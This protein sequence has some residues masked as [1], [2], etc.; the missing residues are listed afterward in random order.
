MT[1]HNSYHRPIDQRAPR[2]PVGTSGRVE[3]RLCAVRPY[4]VWGVAVLLVAAG[5]RWLLACTAYLLPNSD[6]VMVGLM[7]RHILAG[8]W[9]AFY[10]GQPYNGTLESWITAGIFRLFGP[11]YAALHVAPIFFSLLFVA[12]AMILGYQLYGKHV[13]LLSGIYLAL[14][15]ALLQ[16]FSVWPGYNYLEA[17]A[18]GTF[19]LTLVLPMSQ[20]RGWARLP[21][22]AFMLG[23]ALWAQ[24]VAIVYA[25]PIAVLLIGP[26][27]AT[28]RAGVARRRL[29]GAAGASLVALALALVPAIIYNLHAHPTTLGFLIG[30]PDNLHVPWYEEARR[31]LLWAAPVFT[32]LIPPTEDLNQFQQFLAEYPLLYGLALALLAQGLWRLVRQRRTLLR[33]CRSLATAHPAGEGA[34]ITLAIALIGVYLFS[35]WGSSSWSAT[36]PRYLLPLFTLTPLLIRALFPPNPSRRRRLY[37]AAVAAIMLAGGL[38]ANAS[39]PRVA[40][41]QRLATYLQARGDDAVYGDYWLVY[42]LAFVSNERLIPVVLRPPLRLGLNRYLPYLQAGLRARRVAWGVQ[43]NSVTEHALLRCLERHHITFQLRTFHMGP[44]R[45]VIVDRLSTAARCL[46]R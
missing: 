40:D 31:L 27:V 44:D 2:W 42:R 14:G 29:L 36:E 38:A 20:D 33:W 17:M 24:P 10:W 9:L 15:P 35:T 45:W 37:G 16:R 1:L 32:G 30:R 25:P 41:V 12:A 11:S 6:Q 43:A 5:L 23:L 21:A 8:E 18:F 19:A 13:A 22:A 3:R 4:A 7:A 28:W 26:A 34:L 39:A 46:S